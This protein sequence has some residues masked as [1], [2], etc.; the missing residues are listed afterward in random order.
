MSKKGVEAE[1]NLSHTGVGCSGH[2]A[3]PL[4][5]S[6]SYTSPALLPG[7]TE[8]PH[9]P[10]RKHCS[11]VRTCLPPCT[12]QTAS[13]TC[14]CRLRNSNRPLQRTSILS[15]HLSSPWQTW[16]PACPGSTN[17]LSPSHLPAAP[18]LGNKGAHILGL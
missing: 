13:P 7:A 17:H 16:A 14:S 2:E 9:R 18:V 10:L 11:H 1:R 3:S 6:A 12:E 5:L 8:N 15:S 4:H